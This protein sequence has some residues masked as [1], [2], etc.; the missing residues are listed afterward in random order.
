VFSFSYSAFFS[1][2]DEMANVSLEDHSVCTFPYV[3]VEYGERKTGDKKN[4]SVGIAS[5]PFSW[6]KRAHSLMLIIFGICGEI[7]ELIANHRRFE[8]VVRFVF[9]SMM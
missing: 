5:R 7:R 2:L 1:W 3:Q 6:G 8:C 9:K 4:L